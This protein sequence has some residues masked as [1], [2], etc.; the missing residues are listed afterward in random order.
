MKVFAVSVYKHF[1]FPDPTNFEDDDVILLEHLQNTFLKMDFKL[2]PYDDSIIYMGRTIEPFIISDDDEDDDLMYMATTR[3]DDIEIKT[4]DDSLVYVS[5]TKAEKIKFEHED[6]SLVYV[7][8]TKAE[9]IKEIPVASTGRKITEIKENDSDLIT[10]TESP[11]SS[12]DM[13]RKE[14]ESDHNLTNS[15]KKQ[16]C[17]GSSSKNASTQTEREKL[18]NST[19]NAS[20]DKQK[21]ISETPIS[22]SN[23]SST[24]SGQTGRKVNNQA[25]RQYITNNDC[26]NHFKYKLGYYRYSQHAY[27]LKYA[28]DYQ[29]K[30]EFMFLYRLHDNYVRIFVKSEETDFFLK[31]FYDLVTC[32]HAFERYRRRVLF[33]FNKF[34]RETIQYRRWWLQHPT[35]MRNRTAYSFP[36]K[37]VFYG[38]FLITMAISYNET[39]E[40]IIVCPVT[41]C[42]VYRA[43]YN[44]APD[45]RHLREVYARSKNAITVYK[46]HFDQVK[47]SFLHQM[48]W[49]R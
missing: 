43:Y 1:L 29:I 41:N 33:K 22:N 3:D 45:F 49:Q 40:V 46:Q 7:S 9:N 2:D 25:Q 48:S 14:H 20:T 18:D 17:Q 27:L 47:A 26:R 34:I 42:A 39:R 23:V 8:T 21:S 37:V 15:T 12:N 36:E 30:E 19:T 44:S 5:T 35:S 13:K 11:N 6:D 10:G 16:K 24:A 28:V 38:N 32:N 4:E 31:S